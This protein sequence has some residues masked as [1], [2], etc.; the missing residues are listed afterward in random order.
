[1]KSSVLL[2]IGL[3]GGIAGTVLYF[4]QQKTPP[5]PLV[6]T[7]TAPTPTQPEIAGAPKPVPPVAAIVPEPTPA[8]ATNPV[9]N[10]SETEAA[11][12]FRKTID[13]LLSPQLTPPAEARDV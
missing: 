7:A 4:N 11:A 10:N 9:P 13:A 2:L 8:P 6:E 3:C 1:M 5:A 12:V